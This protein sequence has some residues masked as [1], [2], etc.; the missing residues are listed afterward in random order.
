MGTDTGVSISSNA[1]FARGLLFG[2]VVALVGTPLYFLSLFLCGLYVGFVALPVGWLVGKAIKKGSY[3]E[4]GIRYQITATLLTYLAVC[5]ANIP[6]LIG[7]FFGTYR[8][9]DIQWGMIFFMSTYAPLFQFQRGAVG[10]VGE[11][12]LFVGLYIAYRITAAEW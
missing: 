10:F 1:A 8:T 12:L 6:V 9:P 11:F 5:I 7:S 4:G 2:T 3:G